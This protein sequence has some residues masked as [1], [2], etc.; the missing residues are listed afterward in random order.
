MALARRDTDW[1]EHF[2][3]LM[4][5]EKAEEVRRSRTPENTAT[6]TMC[7]DFCAMERGI[8]LFKDDISTG[9]CRIL[10]GRIMFDLISHLQIL[11]LVRET[12]LSSRSVVKIR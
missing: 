10:K 11:F 1:K 2:Q 4:F 9:K 5:S 6:C 12:D 3:L 7:G 8:S